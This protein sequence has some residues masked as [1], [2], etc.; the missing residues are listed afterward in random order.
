MLRKLTFVFMLLICY[1]IV[2]KKICATETNIR[3]CF[4][5]CTCGCGCN[6]STK[7]C[8]RRNLLRK[9]NVHIWSNFKFKKICGK[10]FEPGSA[11]P[12]HNTLPF[13]LGRYD[14]R[15][16]N[17]GFLIRCDIARNVE[18]IAI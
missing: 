15:E 10:G 13:D 8:Y 6:Y 18:H 4:V 14:A 17:D 5:M 9:C 7:F 2:L 16:F 3:R 12:T 1:E 11:I